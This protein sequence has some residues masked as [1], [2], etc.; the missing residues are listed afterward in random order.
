[1]ASAAGSA[2]RLIAGLDGKGP[3]VAAGTVRLIGALASPNITLR[4]NPD[5]YARTSAELAH[6]PALADAKAWVFAQG[7]SKTYD[8]TNTASLSF[9]GAP[10]DGGAVTLVSGTAAFA[11]KSAG[12][13][14]TITF[15]GYSLGGADAGKFALFAGSGM[16]T[17]NIAQRPLTVTVSDANKIYDGTLAYM[18]NLADNRIVGDALTLSYAA[19][20]FGDKNVGNGKGLSVTG[21]NATGKDAANYNVISALAT[22]AN[23]T[24][25]PLTVTAANARKTY[26]QIP[27]LTAFTSAG[28]VNGETIG[29]VSATSPG[30]V[31]T[32]S[33][34]GGPYAITPSNANGGTFTAT[35]Y[36]INYLNGALTVAPA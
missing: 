2:I 34:L 7:E 16:T 33:V 13:E 11:T 29:R 24:P 36:R 15:N 10:A 3:G 30:S 14:K 9:K 4:F 32:A 18:G 26:G 19:A 20:H 23:I 31:A 17:A 8:G 1:A 27:I 28:L 25:A 35:N 6:Y 21:I 5:G 22:T 12:T